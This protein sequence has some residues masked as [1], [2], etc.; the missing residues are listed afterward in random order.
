MTPARLAMG[1][2][3]G[4]IAMSVAPV[5]AQEIL[6]APAARRLNLDFKSTPFR[7][8]LEQIFASSGL[9]V[10]LAADVPVLPVTLALKDVD[11]ETAFR[12]LLRLVSKQEKYL[13]CEAT[14]EGYR[15]FLGDKP[16]EEVVSPYRVVPLRP[17]ARPPLFIGEYHEAGPVAPT[18]V[19]P[20][21][22]VPDQR[23]P[24]D[25]VV[26]LGPVGED[27]PDPFD[28]SDTTFGRR[29][30]IRGGLP[31]GGFASTTGLQLRPHDELTQLELG[32][33]F[34]KDTFRGP[35]EEHPK[36]VFAKAGPRPSFFNHSPNW[37]Y[38]PHQWPINSRTYYRIRLRPLRPENP[39]KGRQ[40]PDSGKGAN[41]GG[42]EPVGGG[43]LPR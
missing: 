30:L 41:G 29:R 1:L 37:I 38:E 22:I 21:E 42:S 34:W 5:R 28:F 18:P 11:A 40:N 15:I 27:E 12:L 13:Q 24:S 20:A 17:I 23:P 3:V 2:I 10:Q 43:Y 39:S 35:F 36:A 25:L 33:P 4:C 32:G 31:S 26:D 6:K 7:Q 8:A 19:D 14:D 16:A 9:R